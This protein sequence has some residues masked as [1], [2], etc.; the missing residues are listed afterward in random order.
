M[1]R[2][3]SVVHYASI[4]DAIPPEFELLIPVC[5]GLLLVVQLGKQGILL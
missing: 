2:F 4:Y 3:N 1:S 5:Y